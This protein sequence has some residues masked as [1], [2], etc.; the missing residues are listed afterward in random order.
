MADAQT[1]VTA[2]GWFPALTTLIGFLAGGI[3][4][5]FRD[6]RAIERD[7][8]NADATLA[9]ER[10]ARDST[11]RMQLRERRATFQRETL[12]NLQEEIVKLTRAAGRMH[13]LDVMEYRKSGKWRGFQFPEE[14]NDGAHQANVRMIVLTSR[15]QD[16]RIREMAD[17]LRTHACCVGACA[18]EESALAALAQMTAVLEPIHE[19]IGAVLRKLDEDEDAGL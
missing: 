1:T 11:H 16:G 7:R 3:S 12:L 19:R 15:V 2:V 9:R 5:R 4:E 13:H 6:K 10:E 18:T 14:L 17:T 8:A